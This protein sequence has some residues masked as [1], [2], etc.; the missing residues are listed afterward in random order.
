MRK[1][2]ELICHLLFTGLCWV[3]YRRSSK[4]LWVRSMRSRILCSFIFSKG[5]MF[6]PLFMFMKGRC[7]A[8]NIS[9]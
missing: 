4:A 2:N 3:K 8:F 6:S 7:L 5:R 9:N 1:A